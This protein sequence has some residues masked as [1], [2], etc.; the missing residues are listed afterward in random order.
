M[1]KKIKKIKNV[2][3][4]PVKKAA[5]LLCLAVVCAVIPAG[6]VIASTGTGVI[7]AK[8]DLFKEMVA[9]V[10]S[11]IGVVVTLWGIFEFGQA[12]QSQ[13]GGMQSQAMKRIGGGLLMVVAPQILAVLV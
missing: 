3:M 2:R 4:N 12:M 13:E 7:T 5:C 10:V 9:A 11:S 6:P 1:K 8:F